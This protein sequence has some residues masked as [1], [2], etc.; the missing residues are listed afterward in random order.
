MTAAVSDLPV[1]DARAYSRYRF[2]IAVLILWAHISI[3]LNFF[4]VTPL[5]P[6]AIDDYGITR[7]SASLLV[8]LPTLVKACIG[9]PGSLIIN[10]FG[11]NRV[12]TVSWFMLGILALSPWIQ[13]F[14]LMLLLRLLYGIG[15]GLMMTATASLIMQWFR[16]KE[17]PI[18]NTLLLIVISLGIAISIPLAAPLAKHTSW[19]GSLGVF[20]AIG[21]C[22]AFAW[23]LCGRTQATHIQESSS[24]FTLREVWE[25]FRDRTIFLLVVGDALV[26]VNYA[27]VTSW[28]PTF[29]H[30]FRGMNLHQA[31]YVTGLLPAVGI[32]AVL[33]GGFLAVRV[34]N[35]RLLFLGPG[36]MVA[37]GGFGAFLLRDPLA[38]NLAILALGFGTWVYQPALLTLPMQLPWMTPRKITVVWGASL[39]IAGFGM[40]ISPVVVGA[41]R[42]LFD[43]FVPGFSIWA[44]FGCALIFTGVFLPKQKRN[45]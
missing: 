4:A 13:G 10:R 14:Y 19:E 5:L 20:G 17:V 31:G 43:T 28:L 35:R 1:S 11:L 34:G 45:H 37:I 38:I 16:P 29:L 18:I 6:L 15:T 12:F 8:A 3:G 40:F 33:L 2:V 25:V 42:D 27:A 32:F 7:A 39:T 41:S 44:T 22:G 26:F 24:V 9:L 30:E 21:L 36:V 23:A